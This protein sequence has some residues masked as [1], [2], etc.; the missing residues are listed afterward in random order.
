MKPIDQTTFGHPG[1]NCFSACVA[2]LLEIEIE[3]V[4]YFMGVQDWVPG[5][6]KWLERYGY[7]PVFVSQAPTDDWH[8]KGFY[9]LG[10]QSPRGP[11]AVVARGLEV[12]HDPHP[13]RDGLSKIEDCTLLVPFDPAPA[14][15][16]QTSAHG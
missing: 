8:P 16:L 3:A 14:R 9:I 2:S 11:H 10:G 7:Y 4:P 6:A 13:S 15:S 1:G 12:V 5:F